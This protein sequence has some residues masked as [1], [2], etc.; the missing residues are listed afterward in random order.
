MCV[1]ERVLCVSVYWR[2]G[3][4]DHPNC[5]SPSFESECRLRR[6]LN[7]YLS[8]CHPFACEIYAY[9]RPG[10][11]GYVTW[12]PE[13]SLQEASSR[14][15]TV[16][17]PSPRH[18][19]HHQATGNWETSS[20]ASGRSSNWSRR[21]SGAASAP[22]YDQHGQW[23]QPHYH[24]TPYQSHIRSA[25]QYTQRFS[26][27]SAGAATM[28]R[29]SIADMLKEGAAA[30]ARSMRSSYS[31]Q[32][33]AQSRRGSTHGQAH[34]TPARVP[35][36]S[37]QAQLQTF[38]HQHQHQHQQRQLQT[39]PY[40]TQSVQGQN[41]SAIAAARAAAGGALAHALHFRQQAPVSM[42]LPPPPSGVQDTG[43]TSPVS[44]RSDPRSG[45]TNGLQSARRLLL[46]APAPPPRSLPGP[47]PPPGALSGVPENAVLQR[48]PGR[49]D[50]SDSG[51]STERAK[52]LLPSG[53]GLDS[54]EAGPRVAPPIEHDPW[55]A[56]SAAVAAATTS[57]SH[58]TVDGGV[59]GHEGPL[60][61]GPLHM[62]GFS[63]GDGPQGG[64]PQR[65]SLALRDFSSDF[66]ASPTAL[67]SGNRDQQA[68]AAGPSRETTWLS[69]GPPPSSQ[70]PLSPYTAPLS[71][72]ISGRSSSSH[73][74][75]NAFSEDSRHSSVA[76]PGAGLYSGASGMHPDSVHAWP[77]QWPAPRV[78]QVPHE[79]AYVAQTAPDGSTAALDDF[80]PKTRPRAS[81]QK[82]VPDLSS[83]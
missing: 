22:E 44:S 27:S 64:H 67:A 18:S 45:G 57:S 29:R 19:V 20:Q 73:R 2:Q 8:L 79:T 33:S 62:G 40:G 38:Q 6:E 83:S 34:M 82:S 24:G 59:W 26:H 4:D 42:L 12:S 7:R 80:A 15:S 37:A 75:S 63:L 41:P 50:S 65:G 25:T 23:Q 5:Q 1:R 9:A 69:G 21:S 55:A 72:S 35:V 46:S 70:T 54:P 49:S 31:G 48:L 43:S 52:S 77:S 81:S 14:S 11:C 28:G 61:M 13:L 53:V 47:P 17:S 76:T 51:D 36:Q 66:D 68:V 56:L 60:A 30:R 3:H 78:S 32:P 39:I 58:V 16:S 74:P 71:G 10:L